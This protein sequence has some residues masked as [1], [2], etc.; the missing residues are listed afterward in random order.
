MKGKIERLIVA[1][2]LGTVL[3]LAGFLMLEYQE[4]EKVFQDIADLNGIKYDEAFLKEAEKLKGICSLTPL[5][6][7]NV[8]LKIDDYTMETTLCGVDLE[9]LRLKGNI[10]DDIQAGNTPVLL[11]GEKA[12]SGL[13]DRNGHTASEEQ[14]QKFLKGYENLNIYYCA[15]CTPGEEK[16]LPCRVAGVL[17][18]PAEGIYLPYFQAESLAAQNGLPASVEKVLLVIKGKTNREKAL[19]CVG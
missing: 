2:L 7:L 19:S 13:T 16:W 10:Q 9:E 14:Q 12:L 11:L 6:E 5:L 4:E 1:A 3:Y 8:R 17:A 18:S 15:D